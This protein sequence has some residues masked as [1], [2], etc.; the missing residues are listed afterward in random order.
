MTGATG[1]AYGASLELRPR[2]RISIFL[3]DF[4]A[5][6][7]GKNVLL[8]FILS[9]RT[10][11]SLQTLSTLEANHQQFDSHLATVTIAN[12]LGRPRSGFQQVSKPSMRTTTS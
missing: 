10:L 1:R 2:Q 8:F 9:S 4:P 6:A 3:V 7:D 11:S 5:I 12:M